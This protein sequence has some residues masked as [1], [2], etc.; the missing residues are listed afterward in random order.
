MPV[1][2]LLRQPRPVLPVSNLKELGCFHQLAVNYLWKPT[3]H[4][5]WA[6]DI[7][8]R[9][10]RTRTMAGAEHRREWRLCRVKS[11]AITKDGPMK[12]TERRVTM[13]VRVQDARCPVG[14]KG[15]FRLKNHIRSRNPFQKC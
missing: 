8:I 5:A 14:A 12:C 15:L 3:F 4:G 10:D 9:V 7:S 1:D 2:A 11:R 13:M 6:V